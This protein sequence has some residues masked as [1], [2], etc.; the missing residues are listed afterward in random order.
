[1]L[2]GGKGNDI[3]IEVESV[4]TQKLMSWHLGKIGKTDKLGSGA[5]VIDSFV[6]GTLE[7]VEFKSENI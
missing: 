1:M 3:S 4:E 2:D 5:L 7:Q 6:D